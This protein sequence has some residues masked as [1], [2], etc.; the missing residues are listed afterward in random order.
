MV[1]GEGRR[2]GATLII[3]IVV[4]LYGHATVV[5]NRENPLWQIVHLD[6]RATLWD[7]RA[8]GTAKPGAVVRT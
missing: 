7:P 5:D 1:R 3:V 8:G 4:D 6:S 2:L